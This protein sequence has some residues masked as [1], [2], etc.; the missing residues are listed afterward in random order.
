MTAGVLPFPPGDDDEVTESIINGQLIYPANLHPD[1]AA[2]V[3][4]CCQVDP[5]Q[6]PLVT[7]LMG[8]WIFDFA[9]GEMQRAHAGRSSAPDVGLP[10]LIPQPLFGGQ[11]R[12][13]IVRPSLTIGS[14]AINDTSRKLKSTGSMSV[15]PMAIRSSASLGG[16]IPQGL[17]AVSPS[18]QPSFR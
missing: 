4:E 5:E 13:V 8:K 11:R 16:I 10:R 18:P 1:V 3:H 7:D 9:R 12:V 15:R 14:P 6:R 2:V 17:R